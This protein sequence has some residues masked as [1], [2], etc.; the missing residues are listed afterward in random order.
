M[1]LYE[2]KIK[3]LKNNKENYGFKLKKLKRI[4]N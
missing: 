2:K 3:K 4:K 1:S